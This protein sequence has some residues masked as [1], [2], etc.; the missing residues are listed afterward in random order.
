MAAITNSQ[1]PNAGE[2][3]EKL[4]PL[5]IAGGNVKWQSYSGKA[6]QSPKN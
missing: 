2:N 6:G 5:Y 1:M 4:D 3:M